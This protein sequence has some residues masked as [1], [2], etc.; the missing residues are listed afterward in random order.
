MPTSMSRSG[1]HGSVL[2]LVPAGVLVLFVLGAISVDYAIAFLAQRELTSAAA[3]AANDAATAALSERRFYVGDDGEEGA[4]E[5][6]LDE[7]KRVV[8]D[9]LARREMRGVSLVPP[10]GITL[11]P[12]RRQVCVALIGRVD[13]VFAKALPGGPRG[14]TVRGR[15]VATAVEVGADGAVPTESVTC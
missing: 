12:S 15:A 11:S 4:V 10:H 8:D 1:Q 5:I 7:A 3:A 13:Y 9:A 14:T 2:M 6:D